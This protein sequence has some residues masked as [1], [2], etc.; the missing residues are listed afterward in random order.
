MYFIFRVFG[1]GWIVF[2]IYKYAW[3]TIN[4]WYLGK[5][6]SSIKHI[7]HVKLVG[8]QAQLT[9]WEK[10]REYKF[11]FPPACCCGGVESRGWNW[12]TGFFGCDCICCCCCCCCSFCCSKL[13]VCFSFIIRSSLRILIFKDRATALDTLESAALPKRQKN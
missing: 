7:A 10:V 9:N 4:K 3:W 11:T 6:Y 8:N 2:L 12:Y 1:V 5:C 13:S